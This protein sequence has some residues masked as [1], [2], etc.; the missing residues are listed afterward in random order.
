M[1]WIFYIFV[2]LNDTEP[3]VDIDFNMHLKSPS[4]KLGLKF[5]VNKNPYV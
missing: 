5:L 4:E 2:D 1:W 3:L